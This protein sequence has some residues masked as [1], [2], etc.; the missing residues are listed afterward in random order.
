MTLGSRSVGDSRRLV[1]ESLAAAEKAISLGSNAHATYA[2]LLFTFQHDK[3]VAEREYKR[4]IELQPNNSSV[5]GHYGVFLSL[6]G[7]CPEARTELVRAVELDP[8]G[9]FAISIAGEFRM[10]CGD[11]YSGEQYLRRA[12]EIDPSYQRGYRALEMVYFY[13]HKIP[14]MLSLVES[15]AR[16]EM[17]KQAIRRAFEKSGEAG[18]GQ[19]SLQQVLGDP[20]QNQRALTL[21]SAYA[22]AGDRA[23]ALHYLNQAY[24]DQDPRLPWVRALPQYWF[25]R[26]DPEYN[27]LLEKI[28]LPPTEK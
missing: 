22:F 4:A 13:E 3:G 16:S 26:G 15:S 25:L 23:R 19:L 6:L 9:E 18:Y 5:H 14:E 11:L 7:R 1:E 21:A 8:T 17:E 27:A 28:G 12:L 10:Y 20:R 24:L 2:L